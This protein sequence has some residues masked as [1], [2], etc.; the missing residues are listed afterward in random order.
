MNWPCKQLLWLL[1]AMITSTTVVCADD[2]DRLRAALERQERNWKLQQHINKTRPRRRDSPARPENISDD[3]IR[4]IE[5]VTHEIFPQTLVNV[6]TVVTGCPCEDGAKC[7]AQ[8]W[9][10]ALKGGKTYELQLSRI[11][12]KWMVGPI[13]QWWREY[14]KWESERQ[15]K[16][17]EDYRQWRKDYEDLIE[18]FP[19]CTKKRKNPLIEEK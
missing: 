12:D 2:P 1:I 8:V 6:G 10:T 14:E 9:L 11:N 7:T 18:R 15:R 19:A 17:F 5:Y 3:E 13:Q 4:E 16:T